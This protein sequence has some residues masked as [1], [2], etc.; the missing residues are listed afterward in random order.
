MAAAAASLFL[1]IP[2][3][4]GRLVWGPPVV[5]LGV[6]VVSFRRGEG[7]GGEGILAACRWNYE[8]DKLPQPLHDL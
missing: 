6:A 8:I 4:Y 5:R 3:F 7:G 1:S 2:L